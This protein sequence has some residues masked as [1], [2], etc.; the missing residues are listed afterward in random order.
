MNVNRVL[1]SINK[2]PL[3]SSVPARSQRSLRVS[4]AN[5]GRKTSPKMRT[6][7]RMQNCRTQRIPSE[8][9]AESGGAASTVAPGH[10]T[11]TSGRAAGVAAAPTWRR[12]PGARLSR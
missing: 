7:S 9:E 6:I 8:G 4:A 11:P 5:R 10:R 3:Q 1:R 12:G 2:A